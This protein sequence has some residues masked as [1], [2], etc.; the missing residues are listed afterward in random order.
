[1]Y[2]PMNFK[3]M[4]VAINP[5]YLGGP[6]LLEKVCGVVML[7][8][9]YYLL[10]SRGPLPQDLLCHAHAPAGS[11]MERARATWP[12]RTAAMATPR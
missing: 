5:E 7:R 10:A 8:V 1:M 12:R 11:D 9:H 3:Q 2:A 4:K 6:G